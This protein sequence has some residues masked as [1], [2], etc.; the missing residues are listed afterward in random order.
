[1][2]DTSYRFIP[3]YQNKYQIDVYGHVREVIN[4]GK[5][6]PV[7]AKLTT[8]G[9][10]SVVLKYGKPSWVGIHRL[11]AKTFLSNPENLTDV[12]HLDSDIQNNFVSNLEWVSH[13]ENCRRSAVRRKQS[14]NTKKRRIRVVETGQVFESMSQ[15]SK[16]LG[17]RY[18]SVLGSIYM[19][20][21]VKGF[22]FEDI[23]DTEV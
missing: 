16:T 5:F 2:Y 19:K 8:D 7:V 22:T 6:Q 23:K 11:V 9:Y 10:V 3:G 17:I 18:G 4:F 21:P 20:K 13:R 12:D 1:M 14:G 15:A